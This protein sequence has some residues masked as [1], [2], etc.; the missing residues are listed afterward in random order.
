MEFV[1]I[2]KRTYVGNLGLAIALT[3][4]GVYQPW[5]AKYLGHWKEFNWA[6]YSQM[7]LIIFVPFILPESCRWLLANGKK[8]KC[9]KILKR[10]AKFNKRDVSDNIWSQVETLCDNQKKERYVVLVN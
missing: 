7:G 10:I 4:S 3:I 9:L 6:I 1:A 2:D 8:E 5:L